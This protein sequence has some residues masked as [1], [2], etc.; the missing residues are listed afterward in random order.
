MIDI[1]LATYNGEKYLE[2]QL[3]SLLSQ[4]YKN[5]RVLIHDDGSTDNTKNIINR[6]IRIDERVVLI[7]DGISGLGCA[8]NFIHLLQFSH[9]EF[10][11]FCDQDDIWLEYK[12]DEMLSLIKLKNQTIPQVVY[13]NSYA[14]QAHRG[15]I[16]KKVTLTYPK[17]LNSFLFLN[18]GIQGCSS[19]FNAEM[20]NILQ[21]PLNSIAM[22]DHLL[23]LAGLALGEVNYLDKSL[24][25]YR[26]HNANVTGKADVNFTDKVKRFFYL[27]KN[28]VIK[29]SHLNAVKDFYLVHNYF[30]P[31]K[32]KIIIEKF[33]NLESINLIIKIILVL[34]YKFK[35]YDSSFI[36]IGKLLTKKYCK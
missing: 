14:F 8:A 6:F 20:R 15:I 18:S 2:Q 3:F 30:I 32:N 21:I 33:I 19:I 11:M 1:L 12:I 4:T 29:R 27:K 34:K 16:G 17:N 23:N 35:I 25:L 10:I 7:D 5:W 28:P 22:H 9:A 26:Q 36:L 31:K 24:M 13:S